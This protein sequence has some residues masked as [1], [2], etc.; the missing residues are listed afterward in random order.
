MYLSSNIQQNDRASGSQSYERESWELNVYCKILMNCSR[1]DIMEHLSYGL[2][3]IQSGPLSSTAEFISSRVQN[4]GNKGAFISE[5]HKHDR[6]G[7]TYCQSLM[8]PGKTAEHS[9]FL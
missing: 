9:S 4:N 2:Q 6:D 3:N 1:L 8:Q 5:I 7:L